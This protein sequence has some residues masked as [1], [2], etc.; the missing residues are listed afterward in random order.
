[1]SRHGGRA[2][3]A[4]GFPL[5]PPWTTRFPWVS[6]PEQALRTSL[7]ALPAIVTSTRTKH[8]SG[9]RSTCRPSR[10]SPKRGRDAIHVL[11]RPGEGRDSARGRASVFLPLGTVCT[12]RRLSTSFSIRPTADRRR[13]LRPGLLPPRAFR[14]PC[15]PSSVGVVTGPREAIPMSFAVSH[16]LLGLLR[17][18]GRDSVAPSVSR[19]RRA[20]FRRASV[21][22]CGVEEA[23]ASRSRSPRAVELPGGISCVSRRSAWRSVAGS[24]AAITRNGRSSIAPGKESGGII[25]SPRGCAPPSCQHGDEGLADPRAVSVSPTSYVGPGRSHVFRSS[26][27]IGVRLG[28]LLHRLPSCAARTGRRSRLRHEVTPTPF[29]RSA[30]GELDL[31]HRASLSWNGVR[32]SKSRRAS[33]GRSP[34]S[35]SVA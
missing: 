12:G 8:E 20:P 14:T 23:V 34:T 27:V 6:S 21:R 4:L 28:A 7:H 3:L 31:L 25:G 30:G 9:R 16:R 26:G 10:S 32:S 11:S 17:R 19:S 29:D 2:G 5:V 24:P 13:S 22:S 18:F 33:L 1:M 15:E 35:G